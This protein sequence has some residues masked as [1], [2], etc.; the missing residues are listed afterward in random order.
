M[1]C[2]YCGKPLHKE[3]TSGWHSKCIHKFFNTDQL[4]DMQAGKEQLEML[5]QIKTQTVQGVQ[6]KISLHLSKMENPRLTLVNYPAGYILKL[7]ESRF[8]HMPESEHLVMQMAEDTG[9]AVA[10]HALFLL[11]GEYAYLT[12]RMDRPAD[13]KGNMD[14]LAMED[15]AQLS[16]KLTEDKYK[17]SSEKTAKIIQRYS[18][19]PMLDLSELFLRLVFCFVTGNSDMHLKNFSLIADK[20]QE[21]YSLSKAYD[22]LPVKLLMPEDKEDLALSLN[23]KKQNLRRGDFLKFARSIQLPVQAAE[24]MIEKIISMKDAYFNQ[25]DDSFLPDEMK[26][27]FKALVDERMERLEKAEKERK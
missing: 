27:E 4:P 26:A 22:L 17:S 6:K 8:P 5:V 25:I 18:C 16:G 1:N 3:N 13:S 21:M 7:P 23:G 2:L 20:K 14:M 19:Q 15:F 12:K 11:N 10:E 9:I 24:K